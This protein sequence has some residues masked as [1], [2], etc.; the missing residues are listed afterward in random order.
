MYSSPL[1]PSTNSAKVHYNAA[2]FVSHNVLVLIQSPPFAAHRLIKHVSF[3]L[4]KQNHLTSYKIEDDN[5]SSSAAVVL[6]SGTV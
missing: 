4:I 1:I 2:V 6:Y 3:H 5:V